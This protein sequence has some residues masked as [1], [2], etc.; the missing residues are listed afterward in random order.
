MIDIFKFDFITI[1]LLDI[2]DILIVAYL[3]YIIFKT[4]RGS[5]ASQIFLG[6]VILL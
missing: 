2:V 4:M 1:T 5:I 6:L 3:F